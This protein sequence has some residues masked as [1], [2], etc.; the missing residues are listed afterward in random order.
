MQMQHALARV[1][2][3]I[4][5]EP[6][7]TARKPQLLG[8]I[9][10]GEQHAAQS[11]CV[12]GSGVVN[13][14]DVLARN[15]E[16]VHWRDGTNVR[17]RDHVIVLEHDLRSRD[18][19]NDVAEQ[20]P[21]T[22]QSTLNERGSAGQNRR[23]LC[24]S[25]KA[26]LFSVC[27]RTA[28]TASPEDLREAFGLDET[29]AFTRRYNVPPS[30]LLHVLRHASGSSQRRLEELRWGLVPSWAKDPKM[31]HRLVLART[32]TILTTRAFRDAIRNRRCLIAVDAFYEWRRADNKSVPFVVR[33]PDGKPFALAGVWDRWVS[34]DGEIIESCAVLTQPARPPVDAVHDRMPLVLEPGSW[35]RWLDVALTDA[36]DL[37]SML[38][39][40]TPEL[41]AYQVGPHVNDPRHDGPACFEPSQELQR[42]LF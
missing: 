31:G 30:Q 8:D 16:R 28:L 41:I 37:R 17:E 35:D 11:F 42:S 7:A 40:H 33:R 6:I 34:T 23:L 26:R 19:L 12:L 2:P 3:L 21:H 22:Q 4:D 36:A 25:V 14:D 27:G 20:A 32:E 5:D 18:L 24:S 9:A 39:P 38:A 13:A 10:R 29:P 1:G 15:D